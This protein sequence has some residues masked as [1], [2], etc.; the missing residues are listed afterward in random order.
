MPPRITA[1]TVSEHR[2]QQRR[3]ILDAAHELL[4]ESPTPPVLAAVA[5][6]AGVSRPTLY[7]YFDSREGLLRALVED[8]FPRWTKRIT[9]AMD[10]ASSPAARVRAYAIANLE[11]VAE[12]AHAVGGALAALA[13]GEQLSAEARRMHERIGAPLIDTVRD[14]GIAA[15]DRVA[16]LITGLVHSA[17]RML[18]RGEPL[19]AVIAHLDAILGPFVARFADTASADTASATQSAPGLVARHGRHASAGPSGSPASAASPAS[20]VSP[21][22]PASPAS[23]ASLT[24]PASPVS[25]DSPASPAS[26]NSPAFP[27]ETPTA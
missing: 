24:S 4:T 6:R 3:R 25:P 12:G 18:E 27:Q 8:I 2:Q 26:P 9:A 1:P 17:T 10:A 13:P 20:P 21:D 7:L 11:L 19:D 16:E 15:P 14:L 23:A 22:S 5:A